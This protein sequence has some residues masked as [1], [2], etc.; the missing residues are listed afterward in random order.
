MARSTLIMDKRDGGLN[1]WNL[2]AKTAAFQNLWI[3]KLLTGRL[4]PILVSA[5]KAI[6]E[7]YTAKAGV[8]IPLWESRTDHRESIVKTVGSPLMFQS[9]WSIVVRR[10]PDLQAGQWIAYS[11]EEEKGKRHKDSL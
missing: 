10:K 4:N 11:N 8:E 5:F 9:N 6:T 7:L 1:H 2:K 3:I